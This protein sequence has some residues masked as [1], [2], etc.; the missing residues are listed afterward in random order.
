MSEASQAVLVCK[1]ISNVGKL[2]YSEVNI[3]IDKYNYFMYSIFGHE[4]HN[5][6]TK[7]ANFDILL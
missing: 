1:I 3:F 2:L 5:K 4:K 7:I 6:E